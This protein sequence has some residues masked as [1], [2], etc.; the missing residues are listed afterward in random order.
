VPDDV[1][2]PIR[3]GPLPDEPGRLQFRTVQ[4]YDNGEVDRWIDDW[5]EGAPEP[6]APGPVLDLVPGGPG[7]IRATTASSITTTASTTTTS[8]AAT[9]AETDRAALQDSDGHSDSTVVPFAVGAVALL[10]I[11]GGVFAFI[12]SRRSPRT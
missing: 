10:A 2:L 12:R 9:T 3:L 8:T 11:A 7:G 1:E 5:P 6:P 4:T